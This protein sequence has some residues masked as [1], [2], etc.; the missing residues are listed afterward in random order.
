MGLL[1]SDTRRKTF[2]AI[3]GEISNEA[4]Q[5]WEGQGK[6]IDSGFLFDGRWEKFL[7]RASKFARLARG[8]II[9]ELLGAEDL[10]EQSL[11]WKRKWDNRLW[12]WFLSSMT[13]RTFVRTVLREPGLEFVPANVSIAAFLRKRFQQASQSFLFR[14]SPWMWAL[15]KGRIES[16]GPLPEHLQEQNFEL[17][18]SRVDTVVIETV[19]LD[20][21]L[22]STDQPFALP[23]DAFSLS[24][25]M[26]YCDQGSYEKIWENLIGKSNSGARY[27]E[28]N[29]LVNYELP[30]EVSSRL[31]LD[32]SLADSLDSQDRSVVYS[33]LVASLKA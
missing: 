2:Q 30:Q 25:F 26:S 19:S 6:S 3:R 13:S 27:C 28:R 5:F 9:D 15:M 14:E 17:L 1:P 7:H 20:D 24:D 29:F 10:E 22:R 8:R 23:F 16:G 12:S 4:C 11:I 31:V 21:C 32:R 33:F 18:R